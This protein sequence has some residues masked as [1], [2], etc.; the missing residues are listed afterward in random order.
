MI[1]E[2]KVFLD[3]GVAWKNPN[4][5][6]SLICV[7]HT[8]IDHCNALPM[9]LRTPAKDVSILAPAN[10]LHPLREM[11]D[12]TWSMKRTDWDPNSRARMPDRPSAPWNCSIEDVGD[13][14]LIGQR[15][16][17]RRWVPVQSGDHFSIPK[18]DWSVEIVRCFHTI[19]DVGYLLCESVSRKEGID[20]EAQL[21]LTEIEGTLAVLKQNGDK[22]AAAAHGRKIGELMRSK[23][24]REVK[25]A[26]PR[27]AFLCDTT[28]QVF[29]PCSACLAGGQCAF[30]TSNPYVP[31]CGPI[32]ELEEQARRI[33]ECST[34]VVE[35]SFVAID[36]EEAQAEK[37]AVKRGHI[38]WPQL[39]I[40]VEAHAE[41]EFILVHFSERYSDKELRDHF[42]E[43]SSCG[44][45]LG[46]VLL[47][48]DEGLSRGTGVQL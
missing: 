45:P 5:M 24:I 38:A 9:L 17:L 44:G 6:P 12:L 31:P 16:G 19:E 36:M 11:T 23:R 25:T 46:N 28:V 10:H 48:L 34:I 47:W 2:L 7:T 32:A 13:A 35:C 41:I 22:K 8:H 21:E 15:D 39:R 29:G 40:I 37:E 4:P 18:R 27:F 33:F 26:L 14:A 20:A 30:A 3:A 43:A 1:E 42:A